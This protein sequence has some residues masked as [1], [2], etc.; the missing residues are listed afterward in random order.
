KKDRGEK[1]YTPNDP[2]LRS[3]EMRDGIGHTVDGLEVAIGSDSEKMVYHEF[4]TSRMP[5]RPVLG[6]AAEH[7]RDRIVNE[8]G[9]A[10]IAGIIGS[11]LYRPPAIEDGGGA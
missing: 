10:V 11:G 8:L 5:P 6:P 9:A 3:G 4:G 7:H 2:L 1:G